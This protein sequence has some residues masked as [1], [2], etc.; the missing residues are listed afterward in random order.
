MKIE[1]EDI[2]PCNKKIHLDI[3]HQDYKKE[4]N[5]YYRSLSREVS[6]PGF[7]KG[8]VPT[9][10]L[11]KRFGPRVKQEVLTQLIS[12]RVNQ[13]IEEKGLRAVSRPNLLEVH[14][15]EGTDIAVSA[16]VEVLPEFDLKDYSSL[17]L[18]LKIPRVTDEEVNEVVESY[19]QRH[20]KSVPVEGRAARENDILKIDFVGTLDGKTFEGGEARGYVIQLGGKQLIQGLE[21]ALQ[22]MKI[23]EQKNVKITIPENYFDKNIAGREVD[24]Q[25]TLHGIQV[26]ELPEVTDEFAQAVLADNKF[27]NVEDMKKRIREGIEKHERKQARKTAQKQLAEKI[28]E[29]NPITMPE[30]L[31]QEQIRHMVSEAKKKQDPTRTHDHGHDPEKD[32]PVTQADQEKYRESA[33]KIL[34]QELLIDKLST[35]LGIE[36]EPKELDAE[37]NQLARLLGMENVGKARKEW[38]RTGV[39]AKL[40]NRMRREKTLDTVLDQIKLKE[41]MVDRKEIIADNQS[42]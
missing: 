12:D 18:E 25:I 13:A 2:D 34:Q 3:P 17:E 28:T 9:S 26:K 38:E 40:H 32:T 29:M 23:G 35:G 37:V 7:R 19:R 11:E 24:F 6:V 5:N 20:A 31:V 10:I 22:G 36:I 15:E 41:E 4:V 42:K 33:I 8:K 21:D 14:A 16:S 27:E 39:L 1:I 30:G